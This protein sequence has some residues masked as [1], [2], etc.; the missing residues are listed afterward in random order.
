[1]RACFFALLGL[2]LFLAAAAAQ[3][4]N[5]PFPAARGGKMPADFEPQR[6]FD[7]LFGK[8]AAKAENEELLAKVDISWGEESRMG[9]QLLD[10]LK[11]RLAMQNRKLLDRGRDVQYVAQLA[12]VLQPQMK[13]AERYKKLHIHIANWDSPNAYALPGGHLIV[14]KEMLD[15][16]GCEAALVCVI[17]HELSHLDRG[18][19][20]RRAK[21]WKLAQEQVT[22]PPTDFSFDKMLSKFGQMQQVFRLP[23]NPDQEAEADRD[24]IAWAYG[25]D[26]DPRTVEQVYDAMQ[27]GGAAT[28][29]FL[30]AFLRTHPLT[31]ERRENLRATFLELQA[32][33][34]NERL[35]LGRENLKLRTTR[36]VRE[37]VD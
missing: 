21:Q 8:A 28:S 30:P 1:M 27:R 15:Q 6:F 31:A 35:Y 26:Y 33:A 13:Q 34:P 7:A 5:V 36:Q 16:A 29:D 18:H 12:A 17:G 20:L 3:P 10:D 32:A 19:L 37:F 23:F 2:L 11:E 14:A 22:K 24:G 9:Q 4:P 25:A